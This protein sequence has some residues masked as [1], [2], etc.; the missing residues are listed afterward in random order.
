MHELRRNHFKHPD[1]LQIAKEI[2]AKWQ[3]RVEEK[4]TKRQEEQES[5]QKLNYIDLFMPP[6][7]KA[8]QDELKKQGLL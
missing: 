6:D 1:G 5:A 3:P 4:L 7:I 2:V 8:M